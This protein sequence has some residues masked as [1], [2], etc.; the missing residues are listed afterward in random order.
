MN[1]FL[2]KLAYVQVESS[3]HDL[4]SH[5]LSQHDLLSLKL[6]QDLMCFTSSTVMSIIKKMQHCN[7]LQAYFT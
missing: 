7:L 1:N 4:L 2:W 6:V 3:Q 5:M